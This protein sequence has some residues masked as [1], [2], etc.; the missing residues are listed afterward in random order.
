MSE[1]SAFRHTTRSETGDGAVPSVSAPPKTHAP[2]T[3]APLVK[4]P[5]EIPAKPRPAKAT[6][7]NPVSGVG[8][9]GVGKP[10][11]V[12]RLPSGYVMRWAHASYDLLKLVDPAHAACPHGIK[13][14][15]RWI[16][17]CNAHGTM[18]GADNAVAGDKLG[19]AKG[20]PTWC[21]RCA[22]VASPS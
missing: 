20:R 19:S 14:G 7:R 16:V 1:R 15:T 2:A 22:S 17:T 6:D 12:Y 13:P 3:Q 11:S 4:A 10:L 8:A 9:A 18:T 21:P 5:P